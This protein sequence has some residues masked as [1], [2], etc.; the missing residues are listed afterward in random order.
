MDAVVEPIIVL[1]YFGE[2][3]KRGRNISLAFCDGE[4]FIN[5]VSPTK[6]ARLMFIYP[7]PTLSIAGARE[8]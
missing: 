4:I 8:W 2:I 7:L 5:I 1:K 3:L 6:N